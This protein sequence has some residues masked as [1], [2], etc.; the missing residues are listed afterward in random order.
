[1]KL[2][3]AVGWVAGLFLFLSIV[4]TFIWLSPG[5]SSS[6]KELGF[7]E[8]ISKIENK[9]ISEVLV[10][11]NGLELTSKNRE[12]FVTK[13][14][15]PVHREK[16]FNALDSANTKKPGSIIINLE[17]TSSGWGS[18]VLF[19]SLTVFIMWGLTLA[20]IVYAVRTLS[21]NKG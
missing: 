11:Q 9:E 10:N 14:E 5:K 2:K 16:I 19:N 20:V 3:R 21:R 12:K 15:N 1:M 18:I 13:M 6:R 8:A 4:L 17:Q 7:E